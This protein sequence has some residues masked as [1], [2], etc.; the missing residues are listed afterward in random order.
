M[1]HFL[2]RS[3]GGWRCSTAGNQAVCKRIWLCKENERKQQQRLV[4]LALGLKQPKRK[5]ESAGYGAQ[6]PLLCESRLPETKPGN[7]PPLPRAACC[8]PRCSHALSLPLAP[9]MS[10][11]EDRF[12]R[13]PTISTPLTTQKTIQEGIQRIC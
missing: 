13:H 1:K 5:T 10:T 11:E 3:F 8:Q 7:E 6:T 4:P 9:G 12:S 2:R